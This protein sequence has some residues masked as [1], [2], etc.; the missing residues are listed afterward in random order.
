MALATPPPGR[1]SAETPSAPD[2]RTAPR[3]FAR[4]G[5]ADFMHG[6]LVQTIVMADR[7][8]GI[9]FT[10]VSAALLFLFTRM[11]TPLWSGQGAAWSVVVVLLIAAAASA[12]LVIFPRIRRRDN[13]YFWGS[14]AE[15]DSPDAFIAKVNRQES[16]DLAR[17]KMVYCYDLACICRRK[18][19][20][21]KIAMLATAAGLVLFLVFTA[22][23]LPLGSD[24][25]PPVL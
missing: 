16:A 10:L 11:P 6:P 21:L 1:P 18:F 13:V 17:A 15:H 7:K 22:L 3:D 8:A 12:F 24:R 19:R 23:A 5:V 20:L 25:L 4:A 2:E 9:L 14:V